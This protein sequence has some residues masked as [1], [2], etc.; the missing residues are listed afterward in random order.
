[1]FI[2][3]IKTL[4]TS[5]R[6]WLTIIGLLILLLAKIGFVIPDGFADKAVELIMVLVGSL[7][8]RQVRQKDLVTTTVDKPPSV[9]LPRQP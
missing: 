8:L 7:G 4:I 2:T 9:E 5:E 1:M 3:I 6:T